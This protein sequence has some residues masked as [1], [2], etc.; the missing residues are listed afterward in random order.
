MSDTKPTLQVI[1]LTPPGRG[2]VAVLRIEGPAAVEAAARRLWFSGR[3]AEDVPRQPRLARFDHPRGE[4]VIVRR[5]DADAVE[6]IAERFCADGGRRVGWREWL[7][8]QPRGWIAAMLADAPTERAAAVLLDQ[9]NGAFE[10]ELAALRRLADAGQWEQVRRRG[11][12][13]LGRAALGRHLVRPWRVTLAGRPNV[14]K[15]SLLNALAGFQRAIVHHEPGTTRDAVT[16]QTAIDGWPVE[17]CD[18][19]GLRGEGGPIERAGIELARRRIAQSDLILLVGDRSAPWSAEDQALRDDL[20]TALLAHNKC[21]LPAAEG[22]RP[23]GLC[24]S[25]LTGEG[26][27]R[28]LSEIS[29]RLV[30]APPPPGAAVPLNAEQCEA[31][32]QII[33]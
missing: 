6:A 10:A 5:V 7:Q 11:D 28:L 4:E 12:I 16:L 13:L 8:R 30:P 33:R 17:L 23:E 15:S 18:T 32:R 21:D 3:R 9:Y 14:G 1:Q 22:P 26:V 2:A 24:V 19:A 31:V 29:R 27:A 25:A 20:S